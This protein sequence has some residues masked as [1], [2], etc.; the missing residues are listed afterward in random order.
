MLDK[1][2]DISTI[3]RHPAHKDL[4]LNTRYSKKLLSSQIKAKSPDSRILFSSSV[5]NA[6]NK[7]NTFNSKRTSPLPPL[8]YS[9]DMPLDFLRIVAEDKNLPQS[10]K[11][12]QK[13]Q[14]SPDYD[15]FQSTYMKRF[16]KEIPEKVGK[17][18]G[19]V[20]KEYPIDRGNGKVY[21]NYEKSG[22]YHK[23]TGKIKLN[24]LAE[25]RKKTVKESDVQTNDTDFEFHLIFNDQ[26]IEDELALKQFKTIQEYENR[27]GKS[28]N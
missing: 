14:S 3:I 16:I 10:R 15:S 2:P 1:Y 8:S 12:M 17:N 9:V 4:T 25:K 6:P 23:V 11:I 19:F 13:L 7:L 26:G 27:A 18:P 24:K 5:T 21:K 20:K 22:I 28:V